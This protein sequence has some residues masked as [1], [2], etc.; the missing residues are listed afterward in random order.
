MC[1]SPKLR[2]YLIYILFV[3]VSPLLALTIGKVNFVGISGIEESELIKASGIKSGQEYN[4]ELINN[5][6][7]KLYKY[8][9]DMGRYFIV[10]SA[11]DLIPEEGETLSFL[12]HLQEKA[13]SDEMQI[14]F[15]GMQYFSE[16]KLYQFLLL[17][18]ERNYHLNQL[19]GIMQQVLSLYNS[20]GYLFAKVQL[21]SLVLEDKLTAYIGIEEGKPLRVNNY[22][23]RGN[24]VTKD[25]TLLQL[26]GLD[27]LDII[28]LE[29]IT[30]AQ[31]NILRKSYIRQCFIEPINDNT[32]LINVEEGK[33]T[34][35]EGVLGMNRINNTT[36][37]SGQIRLQFLNLWGTD[38]AINLFWKQIPSSISELS[39]TYHESGIPRIP[40]AADLELYRAQQDSTWIKTRGLIDI[41]YQMLKHSLGIELA[42]EKLSPGSRF[43]AIIAKENAQSIAAFWN[44]KNSQGGI[45]P[46]KGLEF[47]ALYR[48][49]GSNLTKH[50]FGAT[51]AGAKGYLPVSNHFVGFLGVEI[52]NLENKKAE[53]WQQYKM[54]GYGTLRGYYEDEFNSFRL[55]WINYELRYRLNPESR[56]YLFFDQ[57]FIGKENNKLKT[58]IFGSGFGIKINTRL[59][60]LGLEYALGYRDKHLSDLGSGMIHLGLDLAI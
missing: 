17:S 29:S 32:L 38:R 60:L 40:I 50:L 31:E 5:A 57:G 33:M 43:P 20:R 49:T 45:N 15:A 12:F 34:Y 35:L 37:L 24:K 56:I 41:Y 7:A 58:D 16:A 27:N 1:C 25:K 52:R 30:Q 18:P 10:I 4:P 26:S 36:K 2:Y 44:Y 9:Q 3:F 13:P 47:K 54:G 21:D 53:L 48:L 59:G 28:T 19:P 51:E 23:F 14:R 42:S 39:L 11:P 8:F 6:T 55:G 22:I 46:Y